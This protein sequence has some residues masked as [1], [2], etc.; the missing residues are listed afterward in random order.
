MSGVSAPGTTLDPERLAALRD[1]EILGTTPD[2]ALDG[3]AAVAAAVCGA[4]MAA[5]SFLDA[6]REWF[7][8][9]LGFELTELPLEQSLTADLIGG[10]QD[11]LAVEDTGADERWRAQP[12]VTAEGLRFIA[13]VP[14]VTPDGFRV[15]ALTVMDRK[16]GSLDGAQLHALQLL[17]DHV[18]DRLQLRRSNMLLF[19]LEQEDALRSFYELTADAGLELPKQLNRLLS[20]GCQL[21]GLDAGLVGHMTATGYE[22]DE[23]YGPESF[24]LRRGQVL[25]V[26]DTFCAEV[27]RTGQPAAVPDV[28]GTPFAEREAYRDF[29]LQ[30]YLGSPLI[31][32]GTV[33][34]CISFF[35]LTPHTRAF[36]SREVDMQNVMANWVSGRLARVRA[37]QQR[38]A[39]YQA[40]AD[41]LARM[42]HEIRTPLHGVIGMVELLRATQLD[43]EQVALANTLEVSAHTLLDVINDVLD[44]SKLEAGKLTLE[45]ARLD[46]DDIVRE[47]IEVIAPSAA[48]KGVALRQTREPG[49]PAAFSGDRTRVRQVLMNLVG[50]GVKYTAAGEVVVETGRPAGGA[51]GVEIRVRDTGIGI[52]PSRLGAIFEPFEQAESSTTRRFGGTG[53]GLSISSSLVKLMGGAIEVD[54]E[55]GR[56]S[57]FR[58]RLPLGEWRDETRTEPSRPAEASSSLAITHVLVVDDNETNRAIAARMLSRLGIAADS[59]SDGESGVRAAGEAAYDLILMDISMPVMDGFEALRR[60][61]ERGASPPILAMTASVTPEEREHCLE[62][63]FDD[64]LPK[65]FTL[66]QLTESLERNAPRTPQDPLAED[67]GIDFERLDALLELDEPGERSLLE[68]F[69]DEARTRLA[70]LRSAAEHAD[71]AESR[72]A[73]H[74]LK[75]LSASVGAAALSSKAASIEQAGSAGT[76]VTLDEVGDLEREL[77]RFLSVARAR[78]P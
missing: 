42:S 58:V 56:G 24:P 16:A 70:T 7:Q 72:Q 17:R 23:V 53:L 29:G 60:I 10:A 1:L 77:E 30:A 28:G 50:N 48:S 35:G 37:E 20:F 63:G 52:D 34:G 31:V 64:I 19:L 13:S 46:L 15:G 5:I 69:A 41:F 40:R 75:G 25:D 8:S 49:L 68:L 9:T 66:A 4:P 36:D 21:F 47:A 44:F 55:P 51:S 59:A 73:G 61:R 78:R 57:V 14:L 33:Y 22:I 76:A 2:A 3:L 12:F 54:S 39:A 38:D 65:P 74:S 62:A 18:M 32:D 45:A 11:F 26:E 67:A 27:I 6:D 43:E 71:S